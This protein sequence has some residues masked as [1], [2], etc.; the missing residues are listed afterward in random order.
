MSSADVG[1]ELT[2]TKGYISKHVGVMN[3]PV[4]LVLYHLVSCCILTLSAIVIILG[5]HLSQISEH[6]EGFDCQ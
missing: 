3:G 4:E 2:K 5:L 1:A 6:E